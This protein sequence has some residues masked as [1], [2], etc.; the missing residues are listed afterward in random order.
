MGLSVH[1]PA[2][3]ESS[4][5]ATLDRLADLLSEQAPDR[6][7]LFW[8]D[9]MGKQ[10]TFDLGTIS[11]QLKQAIVAS[12]LTPYA[13]AKAA[14]VSPGMITRFMAGDR[15]LNIETIDKLATALNLHLTERID[16]DAHNA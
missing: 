1:Q 14:G 16:A 3:E 15:G 2:L 13:I 10:P 8:S 9:A 6:H 11:G 7:A 4:L 12:G 5:S